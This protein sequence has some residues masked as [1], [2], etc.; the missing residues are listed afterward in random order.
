MTKEEFDKK[1]GWSREFAPCTDQEYHDDIEAMCKHY[2]WQAWKYRADLNESAPVS[3][4]SS[5]WE[6]QK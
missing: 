3:E 6:N 5:W 1:W 4:F 2:A